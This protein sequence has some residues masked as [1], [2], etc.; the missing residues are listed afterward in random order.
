VPEADASRNVPDFVAKGHILVCLR[1]RVGACCE[2]GRGETAK[3]G[4]HETD[5]I[6]EIPWR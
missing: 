6:A 5:W 3:N 4:F 2:K 1:E